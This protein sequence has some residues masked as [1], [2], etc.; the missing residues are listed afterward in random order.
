MLTADTL[1]GLGYFS[2]IKDFM[3]WLMFYSKECSSQN[4]S[5]EPSVTS[6]LK[7]L[8]ILELK[9]KVFLNRY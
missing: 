6:Q 1:E 7:A 8:P 5:F 4:H 9:T 2:L 3:Q